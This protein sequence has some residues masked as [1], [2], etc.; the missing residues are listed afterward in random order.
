MPSILRSPQHLPAQRSGPAAAAAVGE[1]V[2]DSG[3]GGAGDGAA[4]VTRVMAV[5]P[6]VG[7]FADTCPRAEGDLL[8]PVVTGGIPCLLAS[9]VS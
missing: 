5:P 7:A 9:L 6:M 4:A 3:G 1:V 2:V 8:L